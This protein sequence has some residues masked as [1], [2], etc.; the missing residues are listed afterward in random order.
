MKPLRQRDDAAE[1]AFDPVSWVFFMGWMH[2]HVL[3]LGLQ[4]HGT[5]SMTARH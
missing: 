2:W 5:G 4:V 1:Q 3:A